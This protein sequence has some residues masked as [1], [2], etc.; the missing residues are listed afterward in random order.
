[1]ETQ[2]QLAKNFLLSTQLTNSGWGYA[3]HNQQAFPE[4]TCYSLM[5]L[6]KIPFPREQPLSWL[7]SRVSEDGQL[8]LPKDN[9]PNWATA[10]L[11]ITLTHLNEL[12]TIRESS[13]KWLLEWKSKQVEPDPDL[14]RVNSN[15][16]GWPWISN[17][18]SWVHP[19]SF[20]TLALK[21]VGLGMHERVREAETLLLDRACIQ[22]GWNFGSPMVL[23]KAI[24][25]AVVDTAIALFALQDVAQAANEIDRGL[26]IIEKEAPKFS[27]ALSLSLGILCLDIFN[28]PTGNLVD[29][30]LKRQQSDGSWRQMVWWTALSVLALQTLDGDKNVFKI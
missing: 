19:T 13:I 23:D 2:L 9:L 7:A 30:L 12:P 25:P 4:P 10:I 22:G 1:M 27:S 26:A 15:L 8:Y 29:L 20:A 18:F 3:S 11:V 16:V 28:R 17:T 14:V 6:E 5:A 21:L 24:D